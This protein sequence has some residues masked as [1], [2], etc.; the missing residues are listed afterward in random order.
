MS[1]SADRGVLDGGLITIALPAAMAGATLWVTRF[2]G[3]LNGLI[4]TTT[5]HGTRKVNPILPAPPGDASNG[6]VSP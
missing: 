5:P 6:T 1:L 4:A 3:K 2:S